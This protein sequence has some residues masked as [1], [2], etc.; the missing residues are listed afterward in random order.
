MRCFQ[1]PIAKAPIITNP[2]RQDLG[3]VPPSPF[4]AK[5]RRELCRVS[6]VESSKVIYD[7][8]LRGIYRII[9]LMRGDTCLTVIPILVPSVLHVILGIFQR[10][11]LDGPSKW[12]S[13]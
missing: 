13:K 10:C 8:Y 7:A 11:V 4:D 1:F 9:R 5:V 3:G 12:V 2:A 6:M